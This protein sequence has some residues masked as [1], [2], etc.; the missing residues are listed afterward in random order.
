MVSALHVHMC[1]MCVPSAHSS[2]K[3]VSEPLELELQIAVS[4]PVHGGD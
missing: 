3:S 1:T 2:Q 4:H